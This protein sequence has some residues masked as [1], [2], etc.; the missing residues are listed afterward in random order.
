MSD[1]LTLNGKYLS[2]GPTATHKVA[3]ELIRAL[4]R[5]EGTGYD[6]RL[7]GPVSVP[8]DAR[9]V[10]GFRLAT[11]AP[12]S[13]IAWE[14][15]VLPMASAGTTLLNFCN[16][17]PLAKW[18]GFTLIHDAQVF[19]TPESYGWAPSLWRRINARVAGAS[20][21][22]IF[23]VSEFAKAELVAVGV[24][25]A[26]RVHVIGNGVDHVFSTPPDGEI[27]TRLDLATA[28]YVIALANL[29]PHKNIRVLIEA[30]RRPSLAAVKL[31]LVGPADGPAFVKAGLSPGPNIIFAGYVTDGA[32]YSLQRHALAV[33]TPS[34]T[35]GFGLPPAEGL[36]Q[37]TPAVIAPC[38]ALP[39]VCGP[40]ALHAAPTDP[41]AWERAL[42]RLMNEPGL[43][44]SLSVA[45]QRHVSR[46]T[47]DAAARRIL[48]VVTETRRQ[49]PREH[50]QQ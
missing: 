36:R 4:S 41:A 9:T 50:R 17:S 39:E 34:L 42:L 5:L 12:F 16:I 14:Q 29:Q 40:G 7:V 38:G 13:G 23:T 43:R 8:D 18:R 48:D 11:A 1:R 33:C 49:R 28:P 22:G 32:M 30:F 24:A 26:R 20:Q 37:G 31:V 21:R 3:T 47:W 45:G 15:F 25:P 27:I 44:E 10:G 19:T 35:E 6:I 46:F 2:A